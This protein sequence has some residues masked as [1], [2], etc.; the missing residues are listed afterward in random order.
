MTTF[1]FAE[2]GPDLILDAI[3]SVGLRVDSGL[4][5]LNSY[6][7]R[8]YQF[9]ADDRQRYVAKFY[10][11]KRWSEAQLLEEH[12]LALELASQD[13]PLIAPILYNGL[14]LLNYQGYY[15]NCKTAN[16]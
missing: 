10:R 14:R 15:W 16:W 12:G 11:A 4:L 8:V 1:N 6:E 5:T 9:I 13:I 2:L 3:E 7:N